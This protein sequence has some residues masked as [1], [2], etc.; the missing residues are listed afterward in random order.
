MI[1][2]ILTSKARRQHR[3][4]AK[5]LAGTTMPRL[6]VL[7][8]NQHIGAQIIR[9]DGHVLAAV[10]SQTLKTFKGTKLAQAI[11]VG[12]LLG[13]V[14]KEKKIESVIFDR[15]SYRFHGRVKALAEAVRESGIKF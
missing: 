11:E 1:Q 8:S 7:R 3:V 9:K 4:R 2:N 12:T 15:G 6:T 13:K 10:T 5:L 14:A